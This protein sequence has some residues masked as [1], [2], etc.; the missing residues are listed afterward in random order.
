MLPRRGRPPDLRP[1]RGPRTWAATV[2]HTWSKKDG[3]TI[4]SKVYADPSENGRGSEVDWYKEGMPIAVLCQTHSRAVTNPSMGTTST[5]WDKLDNNHWI[6]DLY[7]TLYDNP[8]ADIP[9]C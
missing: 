6:P 3:Q 9:A 5:V 1:A 2:A 7:T 4:G 8:P